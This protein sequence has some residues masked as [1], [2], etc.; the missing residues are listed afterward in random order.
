MVVKS[1][2]SFTVLILIQFYVIISAKLLT[3]SIS[4]KHN[5]IVSPEL[6]PKWCYPSAYFHVTQRGVMLAAHVQLDS[7][8]PRGTGFISSPRTRQRRIQ[9]NCRVLGQIYE[10]NNI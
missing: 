10:Q 6:P 7:V 1:K 2:E 5:T 3:F 8:I 4:L 9:F